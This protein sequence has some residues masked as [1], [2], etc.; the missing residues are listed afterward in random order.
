MAESTLNLTLTDLQAGVAEYLGFSRDSTK[1]D[2]DKKAQIAAAI[3]SGLRQFYFA[4]LLPNQ[5]TPH[6]WSFL[7]PTFTLG[8]R[9]GVADYDLPDNFASLAGEI[10]LVQNTQNNGYQIREVAPERIYLFRQNPDS[11]AVPRYA[12]IQTKVP[13]GAS[14]PRYEMMFWPTPDSTY[15]VVFRYSM[16]PDSVST[17]APFA[18]CGVQH[19]E[20]LLASCVAAAEMM[21]VDGQMDRNVRYQQLLATSVARDAAASAPDFIGGRQRRLRAPTYERRSDGQGVRIEG[22][23]F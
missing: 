23:H 3:A 4:P 14:T 22:F 1:W 5:M 11:P 6:E 20:T 12:A 19:A 18:A 7:K 9:D 10:T 13:A 2:D 17:S 21:Y 16:I 15:D 8:V